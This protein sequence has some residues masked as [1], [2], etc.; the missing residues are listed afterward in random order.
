MTKLYI[1]GNGFDK[2]HKLPTGYDD[3][4]KFVID[5]YSEIENVFEEYFLLRGNEDSLWSDF[6]ADLGTF[7]WKYFFNEKNTIDV[8]DESF[9]PS[10][11]FGL[12]DDLRQETDELVDKIKEVF[13]NWLNRIDLESTDKKNEFQ[14]YAFFLNFNYT[15]T[16]EEVYKIPSEM[17]F[18]IHGDIQ[19]NADSLIFGHNEEFIEIDTNGDSDQTMFTSSENMSKYPFYAFKKPVTEIITE[20]KLFFEN[21]KSIEEVIVFGHSLNPVDIPY[22]EEIVKQTKNS[23][24]WK[25]SFYEEKEK[26]SHIITLQEIGIEKS[27]IELFKM[28]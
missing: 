8:Q 21:I 19:N 17:I 9:R 25:V 28:S 14:E 7:K 1:I 2:Y 16:L 4:H 18:H 20:N 27:N 15:L 23:V 13:E 3:F 5:N 24:S 6:E 10:C 26:E 11:R 22:F 12:E